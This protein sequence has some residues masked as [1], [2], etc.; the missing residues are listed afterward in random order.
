MQPTNYKLQEP[1]IFEEASKDV[2]WIDAMKEEHRTLEKNHP[3]RKEGQTDSPVRQGRRQ[4]TRDYGRGT[5]SPSIFFFSP[6]EENNNW[7]G[8]GDVVPTHRHRWSA[9]S[10]ASGE[11]GPPASASEAR[12][13]AAHMPWPPR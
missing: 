8:M 12:A 3:I 7:G 1:K 10:L 2:R 6:E 9:A 5:A 11:D 13:A 4:R